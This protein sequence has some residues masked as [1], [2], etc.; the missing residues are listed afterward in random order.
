MRIRVLV[1]EDDPVVASALQELLGHSQALEAAGVF[2]AAEPALEAV[3][4]GLELDVAVVDLGLPGMSGRTLIGKLAAARP[5]LAIVVLTIFDDDDNLFAALHAGATGYL[6][7][8][9]SAERIVTGIIDAANGGAPMSPGIARRVLAELRV[10]RGRAPG[11]PPDDAAVTPLTGRE[12]EVVE[13][14]A[15]G[16]TYEMIARALGIAKTTVQT[17]IKAIYRKLEVVDKAE[18]TAEAYRR[19]IIS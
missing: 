9:A 3:A 10:R 14:L 15:R 19:G 7:K 4:R 17:H 18:A 1:V 5:G 16:L 6:L 11:S 2:G 8:D 13:L 12:L